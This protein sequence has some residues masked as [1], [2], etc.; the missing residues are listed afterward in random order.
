[1]DNQ[2]LFDASKK[3][4]Q[5]SK[6]ESISATP[7]MTSSKLNISK[8]IQTLIKNYSDSLN[9]KEQQYTPIQVD[10]IASKIA[11]FYELARK[12]IDWKDDNLLRRGAAER[13][14]KRMLIAKVSGILQISQVNPYKVAESL[15]KELIRG[16]HLPNNEIAQ[17]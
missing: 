17:E 11:K 3:I 5:F 13:I 14:L 9:Y 16:G 12:V 4:N 1:M 10:E 8:P 2:P 6:K 7:A 15:V